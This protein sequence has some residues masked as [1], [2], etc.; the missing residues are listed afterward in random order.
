MIHALLIASEAVEQALSGGLCAKNT[1][2]YEKR[3]EE[4]ASK[5]WKWQQIHTAIIAPS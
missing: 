3:A 4:Q 5:I 1:D 2:D